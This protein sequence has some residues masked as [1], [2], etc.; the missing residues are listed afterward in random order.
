MVRKIVEE[1]LAERSKHGIKVRQPLNYYS[2]S[3][4]RNLPDQLKQITAEELNVK[5]IKFGEDK[6]DTQITNELKEEGILRELVRAVNNLRKDKKL[7]INDQVDLVYQTDS[8]ELKLVINKYQK[9]LQENTRSLSIK[10]S[11]SLDLDTAEEIKVDNHLIKIIL[12]S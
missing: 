7:T 2:T 9:E 5:E 3:Q 12:H 1:G 4:V 6:L 11:T 10:D 8:P